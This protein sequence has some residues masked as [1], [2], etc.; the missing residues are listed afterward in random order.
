MRNGMRLWVDQSLALLDALRIQKAHIVANS[1]GG[2]IALHLL[3]EAPERF[4]RVVLMGPVGAPHQMTPEIDRLWGLYKDPSVIM[5]RNV[6]RWF[7][8]D[9]AFLGDRL[10]GIAKTRFEAAMNPDVERFDRAT[11]ADG[12][13]FV[14][15]APRRR[16]SHARTF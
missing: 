9:E 5:F 8:Y 13:V 7:V 6:I 3:M 14:K 16:F 4:D 11:R 1:M 12:F 2:A 15:E 10:D